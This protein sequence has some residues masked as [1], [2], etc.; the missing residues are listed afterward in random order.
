MSLQLRLFVSPFT[1]YMWL[2]VKHFKSYPDSRTRMKL[3]FGSI[4]TKTFAMLLFDL[5]RVKSRNVEKNICITAPAFLRSFRGQTCLLCETLFFGQTRLAPKPESPVS[6]RSYWMGSRVCYAE[7]SLPH[8]HDVNPKTSK[9]KDKLQ[10]WISLCAV[11]MQAETKPIGLKAV[12]S[13]LES[14]YISHTLHDVKSC[15]SCE[16]L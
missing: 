8:F 9:C 7:A 6:Q 10:A 2:A 1:N 14:L 15:S 12:C 11:A 3:T 4:E 16:R 5:P 13:V